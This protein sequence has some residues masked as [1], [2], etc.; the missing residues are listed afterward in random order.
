MV[1]LGADNHIEMRSIFKEL[2]TTALCHTA[3]IAVDNMW[4]THSVPAHDS[5]LT[6]RFLL[7]LIP[8]TTGV[9]ED[10]ICLLFVRCDRITAFHEHP[11]NLLRIA[12]VHL[13]SVCLD[14]Y[15]GHRKAAWGGNFS[16]ML[17]QRLTK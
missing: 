15:L 9:H 17:M 2:L 4:L 11:S 5:H 3:H 8:Y 7:S 16:E 6:E 14:K 12:F 13:S 10:S 1:L